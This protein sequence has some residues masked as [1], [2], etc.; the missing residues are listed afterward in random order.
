MMVGNSAAKLG[1]R[2]TP[3]PLDPSF[4][5]PG[6]ARVFEVIARFRR[7]TGRVPKACFPKGDMH[8]MSS[9]FYEHIFM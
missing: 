7:M 2:V 8:D 4:T 5:W 1:R 6:P 9:I 3:M